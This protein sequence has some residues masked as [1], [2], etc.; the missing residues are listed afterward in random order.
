MSGFFFQ[1]PKLLVQYFFAWKIGV[2]LSMTI[3][4]WVCTL[5]TLIYIYTNILCKCLVIARACLWIY[6][7]SPLH[8]QYFLWIIISTTGCQFEAS[9][10][11]LK[12]NCTSK[13][14]AFRVS[15]R[16]PETQQCPGFFV[17]F[18]S[19]KLVALIFGWLVCCIFFLNG[20]WPWGWYC[21]L[22]FLHFVEW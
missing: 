7:S 14:G 17:R 15:E 19:E 13:F 18:G 22:H 20:K 21:L 12:K 6:D 4:L 2:G 11:N 10:H 3:R 5:N 1:I 9:R 8:K 16:G